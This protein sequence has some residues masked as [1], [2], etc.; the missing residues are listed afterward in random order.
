MLWGLVCP[1]LFD[2]PEVFCVD[3][4]LLIMK[5]ATKSNAIINPIATSKPIGSRNFFFGPPS[6]PLAASK[7]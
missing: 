1:E 6:T 4:A 5:L 7:A 2:E 3:F